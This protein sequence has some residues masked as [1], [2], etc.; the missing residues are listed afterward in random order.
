MV[1]DPRWGV[2]LVQEG[3]VP[4]LEVVSR[5]RL[6]AGRPILVPFPAPSGGP[7][8]DDAETYVTELLRRA[9]GYRVRLR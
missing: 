8:P 1:E 4:D 2:I 9:V 6:E 7:A 5:Q 3:L